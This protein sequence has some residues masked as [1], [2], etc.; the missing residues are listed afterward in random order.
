MGGGFFFLICSRPLQDV[1]EA[2]F[3]CED[4]PST[5]N[6]LSSAAFVAWFNTAFPNAPRKVT[7][8]EEAAQ[9]PGRVAAEI[10]SSLEDARMTRGG[11]EVITFDKAM[12]VLPYIESLERSSENSARRLQYWARQF[13]FTAREEHAATTPQRLDSRPLTSARTGRLDCS[14]CR[15]KSKSRAETRSRKTWL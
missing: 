6:P 8:S 11:A 12:S 1:R 2:V 9:H 5:R 3:A 4:E 15:S 13:E 14:G 7:F 10:R